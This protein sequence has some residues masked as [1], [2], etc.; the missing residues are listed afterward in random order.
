MGDKET[1]L[2]QVSGYYEGKYCKSCRCV[3]RDEASRLGKAIEMV[4]LKPRR[5]KEPTVD[6]EPR[7]PEEGEVPKPRWGRPRERSVPR[8]TPRELQP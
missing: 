3:L 2:Y 1:A 6:P 5:E 7:P 4:E 8:T